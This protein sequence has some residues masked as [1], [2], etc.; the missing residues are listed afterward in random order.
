MERK[1]AF[2]LTVSD[3]SASKDKA[4]EVGLMVVGVLCIADLVHILIDQKAEAE[5]GA[6]SS[7]KAC[8]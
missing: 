4:G 2:K 7:S 1:S 6:H 8:S 3:A 5:F